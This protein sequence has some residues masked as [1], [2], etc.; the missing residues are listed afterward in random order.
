LTVFGVFL[1]TH[2]DAEKPNA[3]TEKA[4]T[5]QSRKNKPER[6]HLKVEQGRIN[7]FNDINMAEFM[8][9]TS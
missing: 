7:K 8:Q 2:N 1:V 5:E 4:R 6:L 3:Q 9:G